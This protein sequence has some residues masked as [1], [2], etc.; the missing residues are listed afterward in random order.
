M[1]SKDA[2]DTSQGHLLINLGL[3]RI[4]KQEEFARAAFGNQRLGN[5][6][7]HSVGNPS[8]TQPPCKI[9]TKPSN[10]RLQDNMHLIHSYGTRAPPCMYFEKFMICRCY[11][12]K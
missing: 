10:D 3:Q 8:P 6:Y 2:K 12:K 5:L 1:K 7:T 9:P 4:D 11:S